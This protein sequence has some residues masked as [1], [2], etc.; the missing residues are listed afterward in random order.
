VSEESSEIDV[1]DSIKFSL[2]RQWSLEELV[3]PKDIGSCDRNKCLYI[4]DFKGIG[5]SNEI[6]KVD[7]NG[8]LLKKWSAGDDFSRLSVAYDSNVIATV[9]NK[10]KL[11]EYSPDGQLIREIK[12][13][14]DPGIRGPLHAIKQTNGHFVVSLGYLYGDDLHR[15]WMVDEDGNLTK[16]FVGECISSSGQMDYP[17]S[18]SID[19]NGFVMVAYRNSGRVLLLDSD[20]EYR[21][22][23]LSKEIRELQGPSRILLHESNGQLIV[24]DISVINGGGRIMIFKI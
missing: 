21:R 16:S 18:L 19:G 4:F 15:V 20:L 23:I 9:Y 17:I 10:N 22:E 7:P 1:Y 5:L 6:L 14:P 12:L 8:K 13:S 3:L 24:A 2:S 11:S